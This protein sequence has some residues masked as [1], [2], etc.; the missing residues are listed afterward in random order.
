MAMGGMDAESSANG[1]LVN[2]K[3]TPAVDS[4]TPTGHPATQCGR[5]I[6]EVGSLSPRAG[7]RRGSLTGRVCSA[8]M[9]HFR[10]LR[11]PRFS[12]TSRLELLPLYARI[13]YPFRGGYL[14]GH[15]PGQHRAERGILISVRLAA[16]VGNPSQSPKEC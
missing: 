16:V 14:S 15:F 1:L 11:L 4:T 10:S 9:R 3:N 6:S 12:A 13:S 2:I 7:Y 5:S 8:W